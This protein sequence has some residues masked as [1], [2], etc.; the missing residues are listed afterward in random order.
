MDDGDIQIKE[1]AKKALL[2]LHD[3]E[4]IDFLCEGILQGKYEQ[5]KEIVILKG[6]VP[7]N[8]SRRSLFLVLNGQ[9]E[10]YFELDFEFE[11]LRAEYLASPPELQQRIRIVIQESNDPRL[12]G[13]FGEV[14]RRIIAKDLTEHEA[15]L[16]LEIYT[17]NK[18]FAE[19]FALL[20]FAPLAVVPDAISTLVREGWQP[21]E[22]VEQTL[23]SEL[24]KVRAQMD[25]KPVHPDEPEV[26]L[27]PV[28]TKW[29]EKGKR[30]YISKPE[31]ELRTILKNGIPPEAVAALSA[32]ITLKLAN[33]EDRKFV[34]NH[35][36]WLVR[37]AVPVLA[38]TRPELLLTIPSE[39]S[40]GGEYWLQNSPRYTAKKFLQLHAA[41][42]NPEMLQELSKATGNRG[43][44]AETMN[45]WRI[46]LLLLGGYTLRN[47]IAI[48]AYEKQ[49]DDSAI[50]L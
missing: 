13:L 45:I 33:D 16:M 22:E 38:E 44:L 36:H 8:V 26:A 4:A 1:N 37:M 11:H 29:V 23:F 7:S 28:F 30:E 12:M 21:S 39:L 17:R 46:L 47:I 6:Y 48:G 10:Q 18:Q 2:S 9:I 3:R 43:N 20:F 14:R 31:N 15:G 40:G 50:S 32:M 19:V 24:V 42:M 5:A 41:S 49:I 34:S 25:E 27:G 35:P